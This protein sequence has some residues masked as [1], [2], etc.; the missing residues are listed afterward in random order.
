MRAPNQEMNRQMPRTSTLTV[1]FWAA[2]MGAACLRASGGEA[3]AAG[4]EAPPAPALSNAPGPLGWW[5]LSE[6]TGSVMHDVSGHGYDGV[7][8]GAAKWV[9]GP[10]GK[11]L[12]FDG[13]SFVEVPFQQTSR[14]QGAMTIE[15]LICPADERP[16]TYKH[17]LEFPGGYLLR[18]DNPPEGGRLSFFAFIDGNPEPRVQASVPEPSKWHQV[19]AVR[20]QAGLHLWLD[21]RKTDRA[22]TGSPTLDAP[23]FRIGEQFIGAIAEVKIYDR[24]LSEDE[25]QDLFPSQL[26]LS[27]KVPRPVLEIGRPFAV[28]CEVANT[29][30]RPLPA[31][32]VQF[33]LPEGLG[34]LTGEAAVRLPGVR[35]NKPAILEWTLLPRAA[36]ASEISVR[37]VFEGVETASKLAKV[38]VARPIPMDGAVFKRPSL[39][40]AGDAL[41]LGNGHLR[42]VFPTNDFG[43]GVFAVDVNQSNRWTRMAVASDLSL[44]GREAGRAVVPTAHLCRPIQIGGPRARRV[45]PRI[46]PLA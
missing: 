43:Y 7:I 6:G 2:V 45:R 44:P 14:L 30:G 46:H 38:V 25:I 36:L 39:T 24:A 31:G 27:L 35:R 17:I 19:V 10:S 28:T 20:D 15:A 21:G 3:G 11:A 4:P 5:R 23:R 12:A 41:L 40:R 1:C 29:G 32:T 18:L 22:R 13:S 34:L 42:F 33:E 9:E 37:A 26:S 16:N 8:H